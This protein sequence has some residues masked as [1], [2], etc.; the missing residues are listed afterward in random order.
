MPINHNV[1]RFRFKLPDG[2]VSGLHVA[3]CIFTRHR[4]KKPDG[5]E[6]ATMRPYTPTSDEDVNRTI[7]SNGDKAMLTSLFLGTWIRGLCHQGLSTRKDESS[8]SFA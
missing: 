8:Y 5:T 6:E 7:A 1:S 4:F 3:S 2:H